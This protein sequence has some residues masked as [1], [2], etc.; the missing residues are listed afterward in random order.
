MN[1]CRFAF[2]GIIFQLSGLSPVQAQQSADSL[3]YKE[4][5]SNLHRIYLEEI[6]DNAQI[7]HGSEYIRYG[8]KTAG[9]PYYESD[10]IR[11]G[12]I[13]YQGN[14][15]NGKNL[16]Y[17]LITDEIII[18]DYTGN[19]LITLARGKVNFF[20]VGKHR[21]LEMINEQTDGLQTDG[22]YEELFSGEP[23]LYVRREKRLDAGTGSEEAKYIQYNVYYLRKDNKYYVVDSKNSLLEQLKDEENLLKKYI[24]ANKL[25]FKIKKDL[26]SSLVLTTMYYS[27]LKH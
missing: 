3:L 7:Y 1:V 9:F 10:S 12:S 15:Y 25:K 27:G 13:N 26:E 5:I 20:T 21:F 22:F 2:V 4:S 14:L 17:N 24:R 11:M 8:Q 16:F 23:G 19:A 6:G 18:P